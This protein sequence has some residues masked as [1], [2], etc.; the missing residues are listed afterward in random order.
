M[1]WKFWKQEQPLQN[2]KLD[3]ISDGL[4]Q[5][6]AAPNEQPF[7]RLEERIQENAELINRLSRLQYKMGQDL[8][9]K[10]TPIYENLGDLTQLCQKGQASTELAIRENSNRMLVSTLIESIDT[11]DGVLQNSRENIPDE[12][13]AFL[14]ALQGSELEGLAK[15]GIRELEL[16]GSSFNPIFAEAVEVRTIAELADQNKVRQP[17]EV[18][19]VIRR[20]FIDGEGKVIRKAQVMTLSNSNE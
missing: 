12:W 5:L 16:L 1:S 3:C 13:Q 2:D 19:E 15:V 7:E 9:N 4:N 10:V 20:G 8:I 18:I 17:Y 14:S 11:I 6:L